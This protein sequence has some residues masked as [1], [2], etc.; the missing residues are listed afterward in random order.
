MLRNLTQLIFGLSIV[1]VTGCSVNPVT[2]ENELSLVS[3]SQELAIGEQNY[4]PSQQAQGGQYSLDPALQS[5]VAEVGQSLAAVS[6][7]PALP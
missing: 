6:D 1:L 3:T 2:G 4:R 7:A 5:Y